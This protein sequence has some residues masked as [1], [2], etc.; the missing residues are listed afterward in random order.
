M[1]VLQPLLICSV[2]AAERKTP[3][4]IG[5]LTESWG[6]TPGVVGLRDGLQELGYR[7][8]QDFAIGIRFTEGDIAALPH[9]ARELV[10]QKVDILV[11]TPAPANAALPVTGPPSINPLAWQ[12]AWWTRS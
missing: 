6:A 1:L 3:F 4:L 2:T 11:T 7:E 5:A 10:Q 8:N 12:R 9:A